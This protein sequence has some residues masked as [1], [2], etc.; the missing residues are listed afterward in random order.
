[1][2]F[3]EQV[4]NLI[5]ANG[6][7]KETVNILEDKI[8]KIEASAVKLYQEKGQEIT[9][10]KNNI[11]KQ[12]H[13]IAGIKKDL[14]VANKIVKEKDKEIYRTVQKNDNLSDNLKKIKLELSNIRTENKLQV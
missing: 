2:L 11:K 7:F 5:A 13:E 14:S 12:E 3:I 6:A 1:M 10:L 4:E 8:S 9:N